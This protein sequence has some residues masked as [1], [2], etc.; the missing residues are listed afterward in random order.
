MLNSGHLPPERGCTLVTLLY[1]F[2][3]ATSPSVCWIRHHPRLRRHGLLFLGLERPGQAVFSGRKEVCGFS[4]DTRAR[5]HEGSSRGPELRGPHCPFGALHRPY[6]LAGTPGRQIRGAFLPTGSMRVVTGLGH[7]F[8]LGL[9]QTVSG[10]S[11]RKG[12]PAPL[13]WPASPSVPLTCCSRS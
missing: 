2:E 1:G 8:S 5:V 13:P 3:V 11:E 10:R 6:V 12:P 7:G 4:W 9:P